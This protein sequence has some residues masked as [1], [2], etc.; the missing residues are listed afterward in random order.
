[1]NE[2]YDLRQ[3]LNQPIK[4]LNKQEDLTESKKHLQY[5]QRENQSLKEENDNKRRRIETVLNQNKELL[6]LNHEIYNKNYVT[7]YQEK[8]IKECPKRDDFQIA[9]KTATTKIKQLLEKDTD[10]SKNNNGF[11]SPNRFGRLFYEDINNDENESVTNNIDS[12]K[13]LQN[14]QIN[15]ENF[16]RKYNNN[17][18]NKNTGIP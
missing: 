8:S 9:S 18:K 4:S 5:L 6:K 11:I 2:I 3:E 16:A 10:N 12:T 14:D 15:K 13:T 7:H 1:M 17:D